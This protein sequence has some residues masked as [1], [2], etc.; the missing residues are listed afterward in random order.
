[1]EGGD[2]ILDRKERGR[3][4]GAGLQRVPQ[5]RRG[6]ERGVGMIDNIYVVNYKMN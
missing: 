5:I 1:M 4:S 3:R 6:S 2:N